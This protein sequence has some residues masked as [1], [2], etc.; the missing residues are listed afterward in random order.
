MVDPFYHNCFYYPLS[1]KT[2][3]SAGHSC[4][5]TCGVN[6]ALQEYCLCTTGYRLNADNVSCDSKAFVSFFSLLEHVELFVLI[7]LLTIAIFTKIIYF[8]K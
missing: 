1:A 6:S 7:K 3:C 8:M 4:N 5:Q 2:E